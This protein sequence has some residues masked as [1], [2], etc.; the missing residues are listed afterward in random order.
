MV[1]RV[2]LI[3]DHPLRDL[4][5]LVLVG[6]QLLRRDVEVFL[7]P[8][9][10]RHEVFLLQPDLVVVNYLRFANASF[11]EACVR[12]GIRVTVLDTEGGVVQDV[13]AFARRVC[14]YLHL[15]S[16]YCTWGRKQ[17]AALEGCDR[18]THGTLVL[19]GCPRYDFA[20]ERWTEAIRDVDSRWDGIILVNTNFPIIN[21]RFQS[22]QRE[23]KELVAGMGYDREWVLAFMEQSKVAQTELINA[24]RAM[25][26]RFSDVVFVVRPHPFENPGAY[27]TAFA[28]QTNVHVVQ[29]GTVL[30]WIQKARAVLHV[31]CSTAIETFLMGKEPVLLQWIDAP[32]LQ[33]PVSAAVSQKAK[34]ISHLED[35]LRAAVNGHRLPVPSELQ[36]TRQE[37]IQEYFF[38]NDGQAAVRVAE[39][40]ARLLRDTASGDGEASR[41]RG[42]WRTLRGQRGWRSRLQLALALA[43]GT[44]GFDL[45]RRVLRRPW[46]SPAKRFGP[47]DVCDVLTRLAR[48]HR[49]FGEIE[50]DRA[51]R[52]QSAIP[53]FGGFAAIYLQSAAR[54][55][56]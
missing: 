23:V 30:E 44:S 37:V 14:Q 19:T 47:S 38:A 16:L 53:T 13:H 43:V 36:R 12:S 32:L 49:S 6:A 33:Q 5:G 22:T 9:Y 29:S 21:P 2:C 8:M 46:V 27:E 45:I 11:V 20:S 50:A 10:Q 40:I 15:V 55:P 28:G 3:V 7:L 17:Y 51:A 18:L 52:V 42:A 35:L 31:F 26:A 48:V 4:D 34:S 41:K 1:M 54:P 39:A 25:A 24:T 56:V